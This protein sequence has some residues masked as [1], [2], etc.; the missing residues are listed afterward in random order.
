MMDVNL[1]SEPNSII[2]LAKYIRQRRYFIDRSIKSRVDDVLLPSSFDETT[3]Q[4]SGGKG[5]LRSMVVACED[6][7]Y[8]LAANHL[9]EEE[10]ERSW[11]RTHLY[12]GISMFRPG[13]STMLD[14]E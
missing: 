11:R 9:I 13:C 1:D 3:I 5:A 12:V 4:C 2:W 6:V 14:M 7:D 8:L 10:E